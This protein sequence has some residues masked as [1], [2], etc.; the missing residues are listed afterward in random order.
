MLGREI[1]DTVAGTLQDFDEIAAAVAPIPRLLV[2]DQRR[3]PQLSG[4]EGVNT[5]ARH[6]APEVARRSAPISAGRGARG[7]CRQRCTIS[8]PPRSKDAEVIMVNVR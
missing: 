7:L 4:H 3:A 6:A 5:G 2:M 8:P 1:G